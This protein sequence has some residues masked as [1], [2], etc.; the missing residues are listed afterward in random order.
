MSIHDLILSRSSIISALI[1]LSCFTSIKGALLDSAAVVIIPRLT[2]SINFDG[3]PFDEVWNTIEPFPVIMHSPVFRNPATERTEI[4][5]AHDDRFLWVGARMYASDPSVIQVTSKK[6]DDFRGQSDY[7]TIVLDTYDD[8]ENA[9]VFMTNPSGSRTDMTINNDA[10]GD[11]ASPASMPMNDSWNTFWDVLTETTD[12]GWFCEM[13]I[14]L[15]SLRFQDQNGQ[16]TMG[17]IVWRWIP[18]L[19]ELYSYPPIPQNWDIGFLKPSQAQSV[20]LEGVKSSKPLYITPYA[21]GGFG[22]ENVLNDEETDWIRNDEPELNAGLDI[23]YGLTSNFTL[24]LTLNTDFAQVEADDQ[25]INLSRFSL[26]FPEKRQFFL[27]RAGIFDFNTGVSNTLFYSRR[28]GLNEEE[29]IPIIGGARIIGR[30]GPWDIG[31]MDMHTVKSDSL[32]SEN[33]G[34]IRLKRKTINPYSYFG[35]IITSRVGLDGSYNFVYGFDG[36]IR[37]KGDEYLKLIW[38]QSFENGQSNN[39]L[40]LNKSRYMINWERRNTVGFA[41]DLFLA[42]FGPEFNPGIGFESRE[43]YNCAGAILHYGLVAPEESSLYKHNFNL[44]NQNF[45]SISHNKTESVSLMPGYGFELKNSMFWSVY[46]GYNYENVFETIEISDDTEVPVGE[47][48]YWSIEGMMMTPMSRLLMTSLMIQAGSY[49]DG[50]RVSLGLQPVWCISSSFQL[51][52]FYEYNWVDFSDRNQKFLAHIIRLKALIMFN[53]KLTFSAFIQYNSS[54][55]NIISNFRLRYN[56][57]EGNDFYIVYNEGTNTD[58][59]REIPNYPRMSDRTL[60][61]K[62][63]YTF[64][65]RN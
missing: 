22:Q 1:C 48:K 42:G 14:P 16:V 50:K 49:F 11:M 41:Y 21:I 38:A 13:R 8:N 23:K 15:S 47:Y 12:E 3:K 29:I 64:A 58:L 26:Y 54:E 28:I 31:V 63:T 46:F 33:F 59:D 4:R 52:G 62:Y 30:Q 17:L 61:L 6:R 27:E 60:L 2:D 19:N 32:P 10:E 44:R 9:V 5:V 24:D 37:V 20:I 56:P 18:H 65:F 35:N 55:N 53:T 7:F 43:D 57:R 40:A 51:S 25:M 36:L 39:S 45:F 34:V